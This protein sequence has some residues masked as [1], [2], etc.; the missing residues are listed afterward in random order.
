[1]TGGVSAA[2]TATGAAD[3]AWGSPERAERGGGKPPG[4]CAMR[5]PTT[6]PMM[7]ETGAAVRRTSTVTV[8]TRNPNTRRTRSS[9]PGA[10]GVRCPKSVDRD[11]LPSTF[12]SKRFERSSRRVDLNRVWSGPEA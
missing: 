6:M 9:L 5:A 7:A 1:M 12:A 11:G 2:M 3:A 4:G 10:P 8:S